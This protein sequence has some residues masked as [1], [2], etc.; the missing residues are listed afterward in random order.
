MSL[1]SRPMN[2]TCALTTAF[3]LSIASLGASAQTQAVVAP[4]IK[5]G[6]WEMKMQAEFDG[7]R[8][9][10]LREQIA[11]LPPAQRDAA[12][13]HSQLKG[14]PMDGVVTSRICL[15]ADK[16]ASGHWHSGDE[17]CS[18]A[19]TSQTS[20]LWTWQTTCPRSRS[21]HTATIQDAEHYTLDTVTTLD[22]STGDVR[23]MHKQ[24]TMTWVG[25]DCSGSK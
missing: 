7:K 22:P 24:T 11:N 25:D 8:S 20:T 10:T 12:E 9:P 19:Y 16:L 6:L 18:M 21:Q 23:V 4:P 15:A 5:P 14:S 2:A 3:A 1:T 17:Q 13:R